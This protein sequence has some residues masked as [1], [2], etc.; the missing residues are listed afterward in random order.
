MLLWVLV[1][2]VSLF[3]LIRAAH[4]FNESAEKIGVSFGISPFVIGV[5]LLAI[6]TSLPELISS[7]AAMQKNASEIVPGNVI[8]SN[9]TNIFLILGI[10]AALAR[11]PIRIGFDLISVDI[12]FLLGSTLFISIT[13]L[14]GSF[15]IYEGILCLIAFVIYL[16]YLRSGSRPQLE[17]EVIPKV[18]LGKEKLKYYLMFPISIVFLYLGGDWSIEATIRISDELGIGRE[19][20]AASAVALGTSLPE[21]FVCIDAFKKDK[22]ALAAGNIIGSCI[23]N[24]FAIMGISSL[25]GEIT[26]AKNIVDIS[27]PFVI[28][29]SL[30]LIIIARDKKINRWEGLLFILF[31]VI[32]L[33][34]LFGLF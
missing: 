2:I 29:A 30:L 13:C 19:I 25:F 15:N 31:Y 1:L 7:I 26:V 32:F 33:V 5:L 6:G 23:F 21:L 22:A 4:Y 17:L 12:H 18:P 20:I 11:K 34:K 9:I 14:D 27:I 28:I 3:V 8:G 10:S 24:A 16:S